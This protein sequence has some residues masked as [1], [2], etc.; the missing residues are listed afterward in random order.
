MDDTATT[1]RVVKLKD[2]AA[3]PS[4]RSYVLLEQA[5]VAATLFQREPGS[6]WM[7]SAHT[8][9]SLVLAGIDV[10]LPLAELYLGLTF[11]PRTSA[12]CWG[13][14]L[15][16][17]GAG[18]PSE[19]LYVMSAA[20]KM[21]PLMTVAEFLAWKPEDKP[22]AIWQLRDGE[23]EMMAPASDRHGAI[24][25]RLVQLLG[26]HLDAQGGRSHVGVA[27]GVVPCERSGT[28]A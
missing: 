5:A 26:M 10:A 3:V 6:P 1:D 4:L 27:P 7:A 12:A 15:R 11:P 22:G 17:L 14:R 23:P 21:P 8:E 16:A 20:R 9:G 28:A 24:Q 19:H 25:A 18:E 2:C 13:R